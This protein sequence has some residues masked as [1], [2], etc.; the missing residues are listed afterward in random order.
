MWRFLSK[1]AAGTGAGASS[2]FGQLSDGAKDVLL[3]ALVRR[4]EHSTALQL[5]QDTPASLRHLADL[6]SQPTPPSWK[7]YPVEPQ[8]VQEALQVCCQRG[9]ADAASSAAMLW[10]LLQQQAEQ[11]EFAVA[12]VLNSTAA[13]ELVG[14]LSKPGQL[15]PA[16]QVFEQCLLQEGAG[17]HRQPAA[18]LAQLATAA[19]A[20]GTDPQHRSLLK[21][22][23]GCQH[24]G[25]I[26]QAA[27]RQLMSVP[28]PDAAA[29]ALLLHMPAATSTGNTSSSAHSSQHALQLLGVQGLQQL[30]RLM[31]STGGHNHSSSSALLSL[32]SPVDLAAGCLQWD[33]SAAADL[34]A[35]SQFVLDAS[36]V[37]ALLD[38]VAVC[39]PELQPAEAA[40][41]LG[42]VGTAGVAPGSSQQQQQQHVPPTDAVH[43][44]HTVAQLC[45]H[46]MPQ[47]LTAAGE[48]RD[49]A[50]GWVSQLSP[51]AAAAALFAAWYW[52]QPTAT[53][54]GAAGQNCPAHSPAAMSGLWSCLY[55]RVRDSGRP[56]VES[57]LPD[58][59]LIAAAAAAQACSGEA[60]DDSADGQEEQELAW[61]E[62]EG[63]H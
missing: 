21:V 30:C 25:N 18:A 47:E 58:L 54:A 24:A 44:S 53:V 49:A 59:G 43:P 22:L 34:A 4:G 32:P 9:S 55:A 28:Q 29:V 14:L 26:V 27:V 41:A 51:E 61:K 5:L 33:S 31:V 6:W 57:L 40:A 62:G 46:L 1:A 15:A 20:V 7:Q 11:Q 35:A 12:S 38:A 60:G 48:A 8:L 50:A 52:A 42:L 56:S 16:Q 13:A 63:W 2:S 23:D 36:L 39:H 37:V 45:Y 17:M 3:S 10:A 19:A